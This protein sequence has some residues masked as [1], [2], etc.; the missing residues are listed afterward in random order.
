[1]SGEKTYYVSALERGTVI[2][3]LAPGTALK[4]HRALR[5]PSEAL[6]TIG[7]NL[8][9]GKHQHKDIIKI[10]NVELSVDDLNRL[11]LVCPDATLSIIRD[12]A[13]VRKL[14]VEMPA[15]FHGVIRCPVPACVTNH[16][17]VE[18]R[19]HVERGAGRAHRLRCHHCERVITPG[20][21][22]LI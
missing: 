14:T 2:D 21:V 1:M 20:D 5:L 15:E 3:H 17:D 19:F 18:T 16:E 8:E 11:A 9:S 22:E 12:Y 7:I 6:V 4:A 13:V 10:E